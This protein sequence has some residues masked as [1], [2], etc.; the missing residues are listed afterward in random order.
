MRTSESSR[1]R[2]AAILSASLATLTLRAVADPAVASAPAPQPYQLEKATVVGLPE[3]TSGT[4]SATRVDSA[5]LAGRE[6]LSVRDLTAIAPNLTAF[7]ANGDRTPRFSLRG[8]RENNFSYG[9]SA[10]AMY[11]DDVPYADLYSRGV[12]LYGIESAEFLRGPQGTLFGASRPGGVLNLFTRLPGNTPTGYGT[13][14]Y[15]SYDA[16]SAEAGVSGPVIQ[17][18]LSLGVSGLYGKREG[19]F[20]NLITGNAPDSRET[21]AGRVQ[22]RWT[23]TERLDVTVTASGERFHDGGV[24][25]RPIK[26]GGDLYDL[27]ADQDGFN[28]IDSH[29]FSLRAAWTAEQV[30]VVAISTRRDFRQSL[31]GDFDYA[32]YQPNPLLPPGFFVPIPVLSGYAAPKV[33]QWSQELRIESPDPKAALKWNAGGY[34]SEHV[35][36]NDSG[37]IYGSAAQAAFGLPFPVTGLKDQTLASQRDV[38][39]AL[40]GQLTYTVVENLDVTAGVRWERDERHLDRD[41]LNP[42]APAPFNNIAFKAARDFDGFQPK[43]G[44]AYH[45]SP[46]ATLWFSAAEAY[47][48]GGFSPS[49]DNPATANYAKSTSEHY[50]LGL[51]SRL[52]D[53]KLRASVSGFL[54]ETKDYQVYRPV[55]FTDFRVLNAD[56]ACTWGAETELRWAPV[57]GL[58]LAVAAGWSQAEFR[59]FTAPNPLGAGTEDLGGRT[60]NF[61]P[62]FTLDASGTYRFPSGWFVGAGVTAVGEYW[63]DERNTAKQ[64]PYALVRIRAGWEKGNFGVA[65]FAHNLTDTHYYANALDLGPSQGFVGTPGDPQVFGIE[66]TGRF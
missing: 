23:P 53:G 62:Q 14:R 47:Q 45:L 1:P 59:N 5:D 25:T 26:A 24:V 19:F 44:L 64:S 18:T 13:L 3:S 6:L 46:E 15:G 10:V 22:A 35:L 21:L 29:T 8:L 51:T 30:R 55:S 33:G 58:E 65:A 16:L 34:W 48:P 40:F 17:D 50:E 39:F 63:F 32:E 9:E 38:N 43:A 12:P 42:L 28:H 2:L 54:I 20:H 60:I 66:V 36:R 57:R 37:Y 61:V 56:R 52:L 11:I 27:K 7:D 31:Q 49:Q 41:H 4:G